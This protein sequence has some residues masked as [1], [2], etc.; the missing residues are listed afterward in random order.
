MC[1][2]QNISYHISINANWLKKIQKFKLN[3]QTSFKSSVFLPT[4]LEKAKNIPNSICLH[5]STSNKPKFLEF[6]INNAN[7][8]LLYTS[9]KPDQSIAM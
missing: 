2:R 8:D 1:L 3:K 7:Q 9:L 6:S 4:P 5:Q